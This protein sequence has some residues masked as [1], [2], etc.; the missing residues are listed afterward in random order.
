M[1]II[2]GLH[3]GRKILPPKKLPVRP[4]TDRAKE[5]LFSIL[6][7]QFDF[8]NIEVLDLYSGTG[9]ISYEFISR[10]VKRVN[11]VDNHSLCTTFIQKTSDHLKLNLNVIR[12]EVLT[13]LKKTTIVSDIIFADPPYAQ[14]LVYFHEL[15]KI[16][17]EQQLLQND[18]VLI[19]E[20][21]AQ[22]SFKEHPQYVENRIY[23]G[24]VFSFFS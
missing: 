3:R 14:E 19:I 9:S 23:G 4:T 24:C 22:L 8:E 20:H 10:G 21:A 12:A 1:R 15:I 17:F 13:F 11:S 5:A 7:H 2:A 16:V 6:N 18:G